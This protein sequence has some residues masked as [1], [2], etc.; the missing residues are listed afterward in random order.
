MLYLNESN[1]IERKQNSEIF[2]SKSNLSVF[3]V[4]N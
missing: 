4:T 2:Q 1:D 3:I